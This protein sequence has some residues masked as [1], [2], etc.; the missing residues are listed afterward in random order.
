M[1][2]WC[3]ARQI[4][5]LLALISL[6]VKWFFVH[7]HMHAELHVHKAVMVGANFQFNLQFANC[8][9]FPYV[10]WYQLTYQ[11]VNINKWAED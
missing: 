6:H 10:F 1:S 7:I 11:Q 8:H 2:W 9:H 3:R 4:K 5:Y